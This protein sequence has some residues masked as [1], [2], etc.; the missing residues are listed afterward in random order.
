MSSENAKLTQD[1]GDD[2]L[3]LENSRS[4]LTTSTG[5]G[6]VKFDDRGNA[7]WEW[8]ISPGAFDQEPGSDRLKRLHNS[9]LAIVEDAP[10]GAPG[11][12]KGYDPYDCTKPGRTQDP[13]PR[14]RTD[15]RRLSEFMKLKQQVA[16]NKSA[17]DE[18]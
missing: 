16:R 2:A 1:S 9:S 10:A 15:L 17:P 11:S 6:R 12:R 13:A 8:A 14:K 7:T 5:T 4:H 3:E 18:D